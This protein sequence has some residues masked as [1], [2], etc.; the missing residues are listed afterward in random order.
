MTNTSIQEQ[1][2]LAQELSS[3]LWKMANDLRGTMEAYEFKSY[4]LGLLFYKFMSDKTERTMAEALSLDNISYEDAWNDEEYHD[5]I[6]DE[7]LEMLGFVLEPKYLFSNIIKMIEKDEFSIDFLE[8]AINSIMESTQGQPSESDFEGLFDDMDLKSSKLGKAVVA[9]TKAIAKMIQTIDTIEI[10]IDGTD[11]DILGTAY[12]ELISLFAST[13]G[14]KGGEFFTPTNMSKLVA[15][16]ATVGL[17]DV[18][19][20]FDCACGSGSLLLQVGQYTNCR[21]YY[22]QELAA[23]TYNLARMNMML[24]GIR[25]NNFEIVNCDTVFDDEALGENKYQVQVAN[26]PYAV[27]WSGDPALLEDERFSP[28]GVLAP[29]SNEDLMFVEH[30]IHHMEDGDSRIAVLLPH[31]VLF[32]GGAEETIRKYMIEQ[33]NVLDAVVGLPEK[34]FHGTGIAVCCLVFKKQRNGDS[35]NICFIDASKYF[36]SEGKM[37]YL[38]EEDMDRIVDAYVERKDIDKF[39]HVAT[40]D[41]I[42][43]NDFNLNIPRYVDTFEPE[44]PVDIQTERQALAELEEKTKTD[45]EKVN[46]FLSELGL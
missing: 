23:T 8:E 2:K 46:A 15:R 24:H 28:Y 26:P 36:S 5:D 42:R 17:T 10:D 30:M 19:S 38:T 25:Y 3:K 34:C 31:G 41:E 9:R 11:V 21:Q 35:D 39:C 29:K 22:G 43:E 6:I 45:M 33:Q 14:K 4:I 1:N 12:V 37:N 32:R 44:P 40:M 13:A 7:E 18:K 20:A 27:K 16:L